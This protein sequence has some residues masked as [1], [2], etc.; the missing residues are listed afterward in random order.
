MPFIIIMI[1]IIIMNIIINGQNI[2]N[3]NKH[4]QNTGVD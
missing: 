2:V 4:R 1:N 3:K